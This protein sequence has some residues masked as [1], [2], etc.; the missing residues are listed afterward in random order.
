M[1]SAYEN[2]VREAAAYKKTSQALGDMDD[3]Q[4]S[5]VASKA[6][7][8][9]GYFNELKKSAEKVM[10]KKNFKKLTK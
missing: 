5:Y 3:W 9:Q 2:Y 8:V 4:K 6:G 10:D 1:V 7:E